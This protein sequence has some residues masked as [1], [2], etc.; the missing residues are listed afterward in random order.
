MLTKRT[1]PWIFELRGVVAQDDHVYT[2]PSPQKLTLTL[3]LS[4]SNYGEEKQVASLKPTSY[5]SEKV[6]ISVL[7]RKNL[8]KRMVREKKRGFLNFGKVSVI[9]IHTNVAGVNQYW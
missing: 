9:Y 5:S 3:K 8:E 6:V 2:R 1:V 4:P 7:L